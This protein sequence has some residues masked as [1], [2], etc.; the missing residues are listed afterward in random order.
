[1]NLTNYE[2]VSY[3]KV[4]KDIKEELNLNWSQEEKIK[5]LLQYS[6]YE[7][8]VR[9]KRQ[10]QNPLIRL[11]APFY[12]IYYVILFCTIPFKWMFTGKSGYSMES[13]VVKSIQSW[14]TKLNF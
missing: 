10:K 14:K 8:V 11:T 5:D 3:Y 13:W 9:K 12:L 6:P 7:I 2:K 1:M 4:A